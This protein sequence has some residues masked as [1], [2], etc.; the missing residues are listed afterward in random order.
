MYVLH[1]LVKDRLYQ[2]LIQFTKSGALTLSNSQLEGLL[3]LGTLVLT[4]I[5]VAISYRFVEAPAIRFGRRLEKRY[6]GHKRPAELG[7]F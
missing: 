3:L 7:T 6:F 2:Q 4:L 5:L 1:D